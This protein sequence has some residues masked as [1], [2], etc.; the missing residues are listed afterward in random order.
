MSADPNERLADIGLLVL[1]IGLMAIGI[2]GIVCLIG[3]ALSV[4]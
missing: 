3:A 1:V 4:K 2:V